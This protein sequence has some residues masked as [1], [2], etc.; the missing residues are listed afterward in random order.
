MLDRAALHGDVVGGHGGQRL[1]AAQQVGGERLVLDVQAERHVVPAGDPAHDVTE[2]GGEGVGVD[3]DREVGAGGP[4][5]GE[6]AAHLVVQQLG[7]AGERGAGCSPTSV[8]RQGV[9]RWT[10]TRPTLDSSARIRWLT[11]D[12]VTWR[13]RA[14]A[15]KVPWSAIAVSAASWAGWR[16]MKQC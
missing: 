1:A 5:V 2:P 7:L 4:V 9:V 14:A 13:A 12:G 6:L 8:G 11:A 10:T 16:S 3:G 15:S